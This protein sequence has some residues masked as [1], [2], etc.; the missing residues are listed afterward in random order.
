M[1]APTPSPRQAAML[2]LLSTASV[3]ALAEQFERV[4]D[5]DAAIFRAELAARGGA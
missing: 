2:A 5:P 3:R 1:T 4:G